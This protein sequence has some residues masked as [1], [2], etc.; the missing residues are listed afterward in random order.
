VNAPVLLVTELTRRD[1]R[2]GRA[3][4]A[5]VGV[6]LELA[7]GEIAALV[8]P[9]GSGK[10]T[11][12]AIAAGLLA[13]DEGSVTVAGVAAGTHAAR[14]ALGYAPEV[15]VFPPTLTVREVLGYFARFHAA[16][17]GRAG[18]VAAALERGGLEA[19]AARRAGGLSLPLARRLALAQAAL[20]QRRVLLL[21]ETLSGV[22]AVGRRAMC[23]RVRELAARGVAVLLASSDLVAVECLATRVVVMRDG[24]VVREAPTAALVRER[25]LEILLDAPPATPP[26]GFRVTPYGLEVDLGAR[27]AEAALALCRE[28]RLVVRASRVRLRTLEDTVLDALDHGAR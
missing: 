21:D 15:P 28:Q 7:A 25:V 19:A 27:S 20:G 8:G 18:L 4:P 3:V 11:L 16:G 26:P 1:P 6:S 5:V 2:R 12:L 9:H 13:P 22:D 10:T 23:D 14:V 17:A 24:R